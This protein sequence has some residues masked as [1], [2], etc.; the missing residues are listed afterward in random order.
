MVNSNKQLSGTC[1]RFF[2]SFA[3]IFSCAADISFR[4]DRQ[5][6]K[7]LMYSSN[8]CELNRHNVCHEMKK[9]TAH[10]VESVK[11]YFVRFVFPHFRSHSIW[12]DVSCCLEYELAKFVSRVRWMETIVSS[13]QNISTHC[14][15]AWHRLNRNVKV[16]RKAYNFMFYQ[17]R[18]LLE[19]HIISTSNASYTIRAKQNGNIFGQHYCFVLAK[20]VMHRENIAREIGIAF[21]ELRALIYNLSCSLCSMYMCSGRD[22]T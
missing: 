20:N 8:L 3:R 5:H 6:W 19:F 11:S 1:L 21:Q 13:K 16:H 9:P 15:C 18:G 2:R 17:F 7:F 12:H 10:C 22:E 14:T 4:S